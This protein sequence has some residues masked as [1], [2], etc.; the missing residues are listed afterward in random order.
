MRRYEPNIEEQFYAAKFFCENFKDSDV[1]SSNFF[2]RHAA[3][4]YCAQAMNVL[5]SGVYFGP[6]FWCVTSRLH[7]PAE[8]SDILERLEATLH[9]DVRSK[10]LQDE[11][12]QGACSDF[13]EELN[14]V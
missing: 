8:F 11:V 5:Y 6:S 3:V 7:L 10:S 9:R 12:S 14:E 4:S 2:S 1:E 13:G